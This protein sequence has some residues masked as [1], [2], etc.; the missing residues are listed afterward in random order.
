MFVQVKNRIQEMDES[1]IDTQRIR[2]AAQ[3]TEPSFSRKLALFYNAPVVTFWYNILFYAI[4]LAFVSYTVLVDFHHFEVGWDEIL[5]FTWVFSFLVE[6]SRK[7]RLCGSMKT[8]PKD[9]YT[10]N[11][12]ATKFKNLA[13]KST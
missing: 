6:E 7:V 13:N 4:F 9:N 3:T 5:L 1:K 2:R 10:K 8:L 12:S 11:Y